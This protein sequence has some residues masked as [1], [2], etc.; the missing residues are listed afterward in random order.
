MGQD[1]PR[2][3]P[4]AT[5]AHV[6]TERCEVCGQAKELERKY[7]LGDR[8]MLTLFLA[9]CRT[10]QLKAYRRGKKTSTVLYV[11]APDEATHERLWARFTA[12]A[13]A[14]DEKL[15]EVTANYV[16]EHCGVELQPPRKP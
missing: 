15:L 3:D 11:P 13:P 14:L 2:H 12:L 16:R 4:K 6:H 7:D 1:P 5:T 9:V 8:L 10:M